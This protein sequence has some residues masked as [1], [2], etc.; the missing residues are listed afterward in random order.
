LRLFNEPAGRKA[1]AREGIRSGDLDLLASL[2]FSGICN[3][4]ACVKLAKHYEF[5]RDDVLLTVFTDS[6]DL[7]RSR[8][9]E[10]RS[11]RG[12]YRPAEALA[13]LEGRLRGAGIDHMRELGYRDRKALHNLKYFTWVEQQGRTVAELEELWDPGFWEAAYAKADDY[14]RLIGEFNS[15]TG[16]L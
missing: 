8:L 4:V 13:D 3:L 11:E 14:D 5:G 9:K 6:S 2:G 12:S 1:L 7:Y 10:M 15:R 16:L